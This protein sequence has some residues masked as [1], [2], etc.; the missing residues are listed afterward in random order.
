[1]ERESGRAIAVAKGGEAA[2][3]V[4]GYSRQC[5]PQQVAIASIPCSVQILQILHLSGMPFWTLDFG[6]GF[7]NGEGRSHDILQLN[8]TER[9]LRLQIKSDKP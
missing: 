4:R 5:R 2:W 6:F 7:G 9:S 8:L 3:G 1:M